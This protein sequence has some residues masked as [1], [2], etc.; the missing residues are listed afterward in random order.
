VYD[1]LTVTSFWKDSWV[2]DELRGAYF[3]YHFNYNIGLVRSHYEFEMINEDL[4]ARGKTTPGSVVLDTNSF[5]LKDDVCRNIKA[6]IER[7]GTF[8]ANHLTGINAYDGGEE[9][10]LLRKYLNV[11]ITTGKSGTVRIKDKYRLAGRNGFQIVPAGGD[12]TLASWESGGPAAVIRK[13]GK[14]K[15][16]LVG[17]PIEAE[18]F[19]TGVVDQ[20]LKGAGVKKTVQSDATE[21][22]VAQNDKGEYFITGLNTR[23]EPLNASIQINPLRPGRTY[24]IMNLRTQQVERKKTTS[25]GTLKFTLPIEPSG[26]NFAELSPLED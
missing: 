26:C 18:D 1:N 15:L 2:G 24:A 21:I 7:G 5:N 23:A 13:I 9:F 25:L 11:K 19:Q 20:L 22:G 8:V 16:V 14:G 4:F 3:Q 17:F 12:V 10:L 6:F